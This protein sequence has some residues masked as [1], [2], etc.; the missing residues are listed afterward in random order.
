MIPCHLW[1]TKETILGQI[2]EICAI[3]Y[4][5]TVN[6][7]AARLC[8][9]H[10]VQDWW[11]NQLGQFQKIPGYLTLLHKKK[12]HIY[13]HI[14]IPIQQISVFNT[15]LSAPMRLNFRSFIQCRKFIGVDST[16][17]KTRFVQWL[18]LA[19]GVDANG[20]YVLLAWAVEES[21]S[22][23]AWDYFF[24]HL[25]WGIPQILIF[26]I[27]RYRGKGLICW[28]GAGSK[29]FAKS[30]LYSFQRKLLKEIFQSCTPAIFLNYCQCQNSSC[31]F[32]RSSWA[33]P[34]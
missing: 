8:K 11:F 1:V 27:I 21:E 14:L 7:K 32:H 25:T 31:W 26:T 10:L 9:Q 5:E 28:L 2:V 13:T 12:I 4:D 3:H 18:F 19:V 17:L 20:Q 24:E 30:L 15:F 16:F 22:G 6:Y 33:T 29:C 23:A 34:T